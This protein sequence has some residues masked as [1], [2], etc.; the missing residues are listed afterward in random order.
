MG[1][2]AFDAIV[3]R[4][5]ERINETKI[6]L[7]QQREQLENLQDQNLRMQNTLK[8]KMDQ[9]KGLENKL[10]QLSKECIRA[11]NDYRALKQSNSWR[12]TLPLRLL[13]RTIKKMKG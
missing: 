9:Y 1:E 4:L 10:E 7:E 2:Q 8:K 13:N 5:S 3:E 12:I 11:R 6:R